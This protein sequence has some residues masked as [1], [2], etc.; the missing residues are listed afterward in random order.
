MRHSQDIGKRER[1]ERAAKRSERRE[2]YR[3][4][5]REAGRARKLP[6]LSEKEPFDRAI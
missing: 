2:H 4:L 6:A 5:K 3:L 1:M